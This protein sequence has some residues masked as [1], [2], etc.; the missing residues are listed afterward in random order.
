M[1]ECEV[2]GANIRG[3]SRLV[4]ID[5]APMK[6]CSKCARLG[7]EIQQPGSSRT[8]SGGVMRRSPGVS[9]APKKRVP[10]DILD[11]MDGEIVDDF[12]ERI[13]DARREK[14]WSQ[15]DLA[16]RLKEKEGL[17]KKI[18]KG[19][20]PEE[21]VRKKIEHVLE[22]SLIDS[23]KEKVQSGKGSKIITTL[24]DVM[25]FKKEGQR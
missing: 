7:T 10:R 25:N 19:M 6:V 11:F 14:G 3:E 4:R 24:G 21:N 15:K 23:F 13:R 5:G 16:L 12:S 18:E 9:S 22:I 20:I 8:Q 2:C 1:A 17:I